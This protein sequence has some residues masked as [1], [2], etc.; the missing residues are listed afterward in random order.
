MIPIWSLHRDRRWFPAP[1]AFR[2]ERF[3]PGAPEIPR[4]AFMPFGVG[5]HFCLGQQFAMVE[6]A[7]V[8]GALIR[9][10]DLAPDAGAPLPEPRVDLVL[11]PE[12]PIAVRLTRRNG[13]VASPRPAAGTSAAA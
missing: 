5:P 7:L 13:A 1:E 2:P 8:A 12:Q 6:M 4:G 10:Y 11:K 3:L 9:D